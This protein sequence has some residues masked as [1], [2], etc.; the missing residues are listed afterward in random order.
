VSAPAPY[1]WR[2]DRDK[3]AD[4]LGL[5]TA[6]LADDE[7]GA[8]FLLSGLDREQL[9]QLVGVIAMWAVWALEH[10]V[11]GPAEHLRVAALR[12][13]EGGE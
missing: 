2:S 13:A 6:A 9:V 10:A 12:I 3:D 8:V 11:D 7:A 1:P 5:L 4:A